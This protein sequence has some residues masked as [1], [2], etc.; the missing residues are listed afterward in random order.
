MNVI[1]L[2]FVKTALNDFFI[3]WRWWWW[4]WRWWWRYIYNDGV[5]VWVTKKWPPVGLLVMTIYIRAE[6][7]RREA[8]RE[9]FTNENCTLSTIHLGLGLVTIMMMMM[10]TLTGKLLWKLHLPQSYSPMH[11]SRT[12]DCTAQK[13]IQPSKEGKNITKVD[14]Y[15]QEHIWGQYQPCKTFLTCLAVFYHRNSMYSDHAELYPLT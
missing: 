8:R 14:K 15:T 10:I 5:C 6:R 3:Q 2:P 7:R 9:E 4:C 1:Y 13:T 11:S 12:K